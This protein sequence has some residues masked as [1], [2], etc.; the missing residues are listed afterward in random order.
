[1]ATDL[2]ICSICESEFCPETEGGT[3]GCIGILPCNFCSTCSTGILDFASQ[4]R[5]MEI[6]PHCGNEV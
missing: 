1:M 2:P 4:F 5:P 6:C 3:S